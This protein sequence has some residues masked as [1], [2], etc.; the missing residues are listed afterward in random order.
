LKN[1]GGRNQRQAADYEEVS[2]RQ[3]AVGMWSWPCFWKISFWI[4]L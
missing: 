4:K 3:I 2:S 1:V